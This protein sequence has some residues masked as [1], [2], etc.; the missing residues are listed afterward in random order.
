[1]NCKWSSWSSFT[2]CSKSCGSGGTQSRSRSKTQVE[3][4]GGSPCLGSDS[5]SKSCFL[6][7]CPGTYSPRYL[8]FK[9]HLLETYFVKIINCKVRKTKSIFF[10]LSSN[11]LFDPNFHLKCKKAEL[12]HSGKCSLKPPNFHSRNRFVPMS[13]TLCCSNVPKKL[14]RRN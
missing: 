12:I 6:K 1:M 11:G 4:Y 5:D 9:L 3:N 14:L 2:S 8:F 13:I 10:I 7:N